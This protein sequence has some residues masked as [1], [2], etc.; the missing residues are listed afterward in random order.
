MGFDFDYLGNSKRL[1][2][3]PN[4]IAFSVLSGLASPYAFLQTL[5]QQGNKH[6][7]PLQ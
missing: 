2:L 4:P 1:P 5:S 6:P 7:K 3:F